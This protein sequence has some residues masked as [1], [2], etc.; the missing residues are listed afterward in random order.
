[1]IEIIVLNWLNSQLPE[2]IKAYTEEPT[3]DFVPCVV[4]EKTGSS[5]TNYITTSTLAIQ[6]YGISLYEAA[7]LNEIVKG[8]MDRL[9]ELTEVSAA[10]LD[11][12]Y[13]FTD[14]TRKHY[15]YQAVYNLTHY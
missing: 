9:P 6:S 13:N 14:T 7:A 2:G 3:G 4:I 10:R 8:I 12:D 15:R 11:S 5:R 1:M